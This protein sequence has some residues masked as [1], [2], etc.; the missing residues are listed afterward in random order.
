VDG[1]RGCVY[2][3]IT[4]SD[5]LRSIGAL[6]AERGLVGRG[7]RFRAE[8][9]ELAWMVELEVV[10]K[11]GRVGIYL[12]ICPVGLATGGW[13]SRANDCPIVLHPP[14]GTLLGVDYWRSWKALDAESEMD[15][16]DRR[17]ALADLC[18]AMTDRAMRVTTLADLRRLEMEGHLSGFV[19][20]DARALL[21]GGETTN[22]DG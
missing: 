1:L 11:T 15:D 9:P 5:V 4:A 18:D 17:A 3:V 2:T 19:H 22:A 21:R 12:G 10:P 14:S 8:W 6:L 13:P 7:Q 20:K 16:Q